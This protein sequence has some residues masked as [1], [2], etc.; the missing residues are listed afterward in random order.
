MF[1]QR[2]QNRVAAGAA[3]LLVVCGC[4]N[5]PKYKHGGGKFDEWKAYQGSHFEPVQGTLTAV[6]KETGSVTIGQGSKANTFTVTPSTRIMHDTADVS[7][8]DIPLNQQVQYTL[9]DDGKRL[10]TIWYGQ[11]QNQVAHPSKPAQRTTYF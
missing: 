5:V 11:K 6:D 3:A 7:L 9:S 8:A 10:L 2:L 1:T 4:Q